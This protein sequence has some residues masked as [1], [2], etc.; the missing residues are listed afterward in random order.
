MRADLITPANR[1]T[2]ATKKIQDRW[3]VA[4]QEWDDGVSKRFQEKYLDP[5]VPQ[6]QLTL[7]ALHELMKVL[8]DAI[9]ETRDEG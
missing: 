4:K 6:M 9:G 3:L 2:K 7:G 8:D 1:L 5:I